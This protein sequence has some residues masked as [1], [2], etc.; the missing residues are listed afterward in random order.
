M[1]AL[2]QNND[3][4]ARSSSITGVSVSKSRRVSSA[5]FA[6]GKVIVQGV[7]GLWVEVKHT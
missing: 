5:P 4:E 2:G 6:V 7:K 3:E 1:S